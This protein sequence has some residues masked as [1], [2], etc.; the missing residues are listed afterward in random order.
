MHISLSRLSDFKGPIDIDEDDDVTQERER[1]YAGR[2]KN[3]ILQ[4]KD[5]CKVRL[6]G[7]WLG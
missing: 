6:Q 1:L 4:M 2:S 3:D 7:L 5:L